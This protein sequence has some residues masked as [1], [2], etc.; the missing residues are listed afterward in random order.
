[1]VSAGMQVVVMGTVSYAVSAITAVIT[2]PGTDVP[3]P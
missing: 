1:M 2:V 3:L